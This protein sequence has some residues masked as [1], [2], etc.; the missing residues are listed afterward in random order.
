MQWHEHL[1][2]EGRHSFLAPSN[3]SW[4]NYDDS[5]LIS[6]FEGNKRKIEGTYLHQWAE[7]LIKSVNRT[8]DILRMTGSKRIFRIDIDAVRMEGDKDSVVRESKAKETVFMYVADAIKFDMAAEIP[9]SYDD[10]YCFGTADAIQFD[11][12][13]LRIHDLKT[14]ETPA[15]IDQLIIYAALFCLEYNQDPN[16]LIFELRIYQTDQILI[17]K[18]TNEE[19]I[20]MM[21]RI[22]HLVE[23]LRRY[24][25]GEL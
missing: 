9:L 18:P 14:G 8:K 7:D 11:G 24:E 1:N 13:L 19:I 20:D 25:R 10:R 6:V 4:K 15:S 16:R 2:L 12:Q 17:H 21:N 22:I 3:H 5:K 23:V